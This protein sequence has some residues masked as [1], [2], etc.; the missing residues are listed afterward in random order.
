V[1]DVTQPLGLGTKLAPTFVRRTLVGENGITYKY[2][3]LRMFAH[4]WA[5]HVAHV[6]CFPT[7][8]ATTSEAQR[9][10]SAKMMQAA[11]PP[12][13]PNNEALDAALASVNIMLLHM[14]LS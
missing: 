2:L 13:T 1:V 6:R 5:P 7:T 3:G 11:L 12:L 9:E 8:A 4:P 10:A 14:R